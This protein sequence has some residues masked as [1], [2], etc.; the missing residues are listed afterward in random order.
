[1]P[2]EEQKKRMRFL[3]ARNDFERNLQALSRA[4][5]DADNLSLESIVVRDTQRVLDYEDILAGYG[6]PLAQGRVSL[7]GIKEKLLLLEDDPVYVHLSNFRSAGLL[8]MRKSDLI[9]H[10]A[11]LCCA[12]LGYLSISSDL[13]TMDLIVDYEPEYRYE[14]RYEIYLPIKK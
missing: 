11:D 7:N 3:R 2:T 5:S 9:R 1:M 14:E 13:K 8:R 10:I 6:T 4:L 12:N